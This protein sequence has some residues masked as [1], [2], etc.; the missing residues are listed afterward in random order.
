MFQTLKLFRHLSS[1]YLQWDIFHDSSQIVLHW[2]SKNSTLI[3][4]SLVYL[5][6]IPAS[7][8][9]SWSWTIASSVTYNSLRYWDPLWSILTLLKTFFLS[10]S[11][12]WT[13]VILY[14]KPRYCWWEEKNIKYILCVTSAKLVWSSSVFVIQTCEHIIKDWTH[15]PRKG[16]SR[17]VISPVYFIVES[18]FIFQKD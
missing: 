11:F 16:K 15:E 1:N 3:D 7:R 17:S 6:I 2:V 8:H 5:I 18:F 10:L 14:T 9:L 4:T 12:M 13:V